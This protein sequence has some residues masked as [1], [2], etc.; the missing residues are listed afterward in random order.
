MGT[1]FSSE[2]TV[3]EA[4]P[5]SINYMRFFHDFSL[6][7]S[8]FLCLCIF[9]YICDYEARHCWSELI[10]WL[11][12]SFYPGDN[13]T[14]VPGCTHVR[15]ACMARMTWTASACPTCY[16]S[17]FDELTS[18]CATSLQYRSRNTNNNSG[19]ITGQLAFTPALET[20][21]PHH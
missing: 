2:L 12:G 7:Y 21:L 8:L 18:L 1:K 19:L 6:L 14:F 4:G 3:V 9:I 20:V 13:E 11:F 17:L 10:I 16:L 5:L 15:I